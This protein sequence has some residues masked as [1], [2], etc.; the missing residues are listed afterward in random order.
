MVFVNVILLI[1]CILQIVLFF[2]VWR[3][4]NDVQIIRDAIKSICEHNKPQNKIEEI[5]DNDNPFSVGALVI[6]DTERQWRVVEIKG[7]IVVCRNSVQGIVEFNQK[8]L[9]L[10]GH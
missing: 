2:K 5:G 8:E 7:N 10:F 3:M 6:D 4:T 1:W 9:K